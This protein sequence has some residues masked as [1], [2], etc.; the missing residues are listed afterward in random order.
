MAPKLLSDFCSN[1]CAA[2]ESP[3]DR[4]FKLY[5]MQY[6]CG[7]GGALSQEQASSDGTAITTTTNTLLVAAP[8]AG[9]HLRVTHLYATNTSATPVIVSW[10]DGVAGPLR[11][12][13]P[14]AQNGVAN[15]DVSWNL[16]TATALYLNTT[17][18]ANVLWDVSYSIVA[19]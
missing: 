4:D 5:V 16:T 2:I 10:R 3:S 17:A 6:I 8:D 14:L 7:L 18:N 11:Y 12:S 13:T 15:I 1:G 19:D 9:Y